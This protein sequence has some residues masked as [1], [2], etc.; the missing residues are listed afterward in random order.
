MDLFALLAAAF[1]VGMKLA[2]LLLDYLKVIVWP[3]VVVW[4]LWMFR[5]QLRD[6]IDRVRSGKMGWFEFETEM[7]HLSEKSEVLPDLAAAQASEE[8]R[9]EVP[10][11]PEAPEPATLL[12][13]MLLAWSD[14]EVAAR[15]A[16]IRRQKSA[17]FSRN[18]VVLFGALEHDGLI[19]REAVSIARSLQRVRN[20]IVHRATETVLTPQFV[21]DF[22]ETTRN[23]TTILHAVPAADPNEAHA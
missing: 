6:F 4:G 12:G 13:R 10:S 21:D 18:L 2:T 15:E 14:L 5:R 9:G 3:A 7:R 11:T 22:T 17:Q 1:D 20:S 8:Q 23:L 19:S 16:G